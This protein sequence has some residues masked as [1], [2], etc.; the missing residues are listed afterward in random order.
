[1]S[2]LKQTR[3][4]LR[5]CPLI[6]SKDKFNANYLGATATE[7]TVAVAGHNPRKDICGYKKDTYNIGFFARLP[8]GVALDPNLTAADF[9]DELSAW[10]E[11]QDESKNYP[12]IP[13]FMVTQVAPANA[14]II[15]S[16]DANTAQYQLQI[17]IEMEEQ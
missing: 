15:V 6:N 7:Y 10:I 5:T 16:A 12:E 8:F 9:F 13:G 2:V 3:K 4:W 17:K 1:M 11:E 14:G